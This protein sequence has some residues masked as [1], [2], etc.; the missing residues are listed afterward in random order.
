MNGRRVRRRH[1]GVD[2]PIADPDPERA[3]HPDRDP[4]PGEGGRRIWARSDP[5]ITADAAK[6]AA[7]FLATAFDTTGTER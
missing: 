2:Y 3:D 5:A 7:E 4:A 1:S 6:R